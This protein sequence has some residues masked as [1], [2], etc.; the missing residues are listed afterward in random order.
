M[1]DTYVK[2]ISNY[3]R[4]ALAMA[5][6]GALLAGCGGGNS[7]SASNSNA[8]NTSSGTTST[9][10]PTT[11][12][13]THAAPTQAQI[14]AAV[15]N[16]QTVVVIYSENRSFDSLYGDVSGLDDPLADAIK[17]NKIA[18]QV[19]RDGAALTRL[20]KVW[21]Q[22]GYTGLTTAAAQ[23]DQ[24][25]PT[26]SEADTDQVFSALGTDGVTGPY[27][28]N[29]TFSA[30]GTV[31]LSAV[32]HDMWHL[33]YQNQMQING[34]KNDQFVA[35]A[36]SGGM[37]MGLF[38]GAEVAKLP[39]RAVA[40]KYVL[41]DHFFA[42]AFGGSFL[43]HQYLI[44]SAPP[45]DTFTPNASGRDI[46]TTGADVTGIV[47]VLDD[48]PQGYHLSVK[49]LAT[50]QGTAKD[51]SGFDYSTIT[52]VNDPVQVNGLNIFVDNG[53][54]S[55][56]GYAI[57]T[58]QPPYQPSGNGY[59]QN[60]STVD[61]RLADPLTANTLPPQT[62]D[63]IGDYLSAKNVSWA[64]YAG[65][66]GTMLAC[67]TDANSATSA[68]R[69]T[70]PACPNPAGGSTAYQAN[71]NPYIDFQNHHHPFNFFKKFDP[72]T[73]A[74][75]LNRAQHLKD[76]GDAGE[77]LLQDIKAGTLPAVT[78]Y[79]PVG[80]LNEHPG[81]ADVQQ[82]D[83]HI[84]DIISALE[85]SPQWGHMLVVVTYDENGGIWDHV[86]PPKGDR[87]GPGTRIPALIIGPTVKPGFVD[88][89]MYDTT[90]ILRF[91]TKRW[92]LPTLPGLQTRMD[93][94]TA[95]NGGVVQ[96]DLSNTLK[97]N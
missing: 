27:S 38:T 63:T 50:L 36:D 2:V 28:I 44:A 13:T 69:G 25:V 6:A 24:G 96:G 40:K 26:V 1:G 67:D 57:N 53:Q 39:L 71:G 4:S 23:F 82:G 95:N 91:I 19:R 84:A 72:T 49:S 66:W 43:N 46:N 75:Q 5:A 74:G 55:P 16:I 59:S 30:T 31:G 64:W 9:T 11:T 77:L 93:A 45:L 15:N 10:T 94:Y 14:D 70:N 76:A 22:G 32:N 79:K 18:P 65:G 48:G 37:V 83:Q 60:G 58:M 81:Y 90:S 62:G 87:F 73:T 88:H 97:A 7:N 21:G 12:T 85:Q 29:D 78:F 54:L 61:K 33:F 17:N 86:A 20:P 8:S 35:W 92:S 52:D 47:S 42:A 56:D 41:A 34:G 3:V 68:A 51:A 80:Y 89:T